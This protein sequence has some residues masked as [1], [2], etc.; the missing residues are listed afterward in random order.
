M[1]SFAQVDKLWRKALAEEKALYSPINKWGILNLVYKR[2][3]KKV[4][5]ELNL[6]I[7]VFGHTI[8]LYMESPHYYDWWYSHRNVTLE[9]IKEK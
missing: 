7:K 4:C 8:R 9:E 5:E 1:T 2:C 3:T 6:D